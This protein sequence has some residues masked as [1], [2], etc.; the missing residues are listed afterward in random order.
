MG[1][2]KRKKQGPSVVDSALCLLSLVL[3]AGLNV[4]H[5]VTSPRPSSS[6]TNSV[7][8]KRPRVAEKTRTSTRIQAKRACK[9]KDLQDGNDDV[10]IQDSTDDGND[11]MNIQDS[12]NDGNENVQWKESSE[13]DLQN[14]IDDEAKRYCLNLSLIDVIW[15]RGKKI[16]TIA[17]LC[18]LSNIL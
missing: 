18:K 2:K 17:K 13:K 9:A 4:T 11:D 10:N 5:Q 1:P 14:F 15:S 6:R 3:V 8:S 12:I 7:A 16:W